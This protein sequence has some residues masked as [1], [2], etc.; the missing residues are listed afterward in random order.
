LTTE[1]LA[2]RRCSIVDKIISWKYWLPIWSTTY[3]RFT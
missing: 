3:G 2:M 1:N